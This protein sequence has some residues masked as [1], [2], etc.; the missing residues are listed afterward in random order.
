M[1]VYALLVSAVVS[2]AIVGDPTVVVADDA[3]A[4]RG[5]SA[6][7]LGAVN[8]PVSCREASQRQF[9]RAVALLHSF[10]YDEAEK[11]F[12]AI[13]AA[14][15]G[16][17]MAQWG[18][19]MS[20]YHP[21]W[22]PPSAAELARAGE[23]IQAVEGAPTTTERERDYLDAIASFY[24]DADTRDHRSRALAYADA[25][26]RVAAKHPADPEAAVFYAL[27]L[28]GTALPTDKSYANQKKAGAILAPMFT[29]TRDHPGVAH[30]LIHSF[31]YPPL[32]EEGLAPA[33]HY[34]NIAP[35]SP[36]ALHMPSHI[37]TRLGLWQ[38]SIGSNLDSAEAAKPGSTEALHALDYLMYAYL[39]Q[40][41]D[42][43]A[44]ALYDDVQRLTKADE[45]FASAYALA[46]IPARYALERRD[47]ALAAGL[48]PSPSAFPWA[49]F[50]QYEAITH[51]ARAIGL[52]RT[53]NVAEAKKAVDQ[54]ASIRLALVDAKDAYW[55]DQIE[56]QRRAAAAEVAR[57]EGNWAGA[58][59][60]VQSA[61]DLESQTEK[62]PVTPG[63]VIPARELLARMRME[64]N[65]PEPESALVAYQ[66]SLAVSPNRFNAVYGAAKAAQLAGQSKTAVT[67]Y[68][69]L[70]SLAGAGDG[71]RA[72]VK[73]AEAFLKKHAGAKKD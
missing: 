55:S 29:T 13:A 40:G 72:E 24:R 3:H 12:R 6:E 2:L 60:L 56:I 50:R 52:A 66:A 18:I 7:K 34:A 49:R 8:F 65:P 47:F 70:T 31:D 10:W 41:R 23:A 1:K 19:A 5:A 28:D 51:F 73:E 32:A 36:H 37:F 57:A 11:A 67:Y 33:R 4:P 62:H 71:A 45:S 30:Y 69:T 15:P 35:S 61:A 53:G 17:V 14:E 26:G 9:N 48:T 43:Q 21:L 64:M 27:A 68:Q 58:L 22:A 20:L 59:A 63:A 54:L 42:A 38:E 25:M 39:Q 44:K 16:C 46:A